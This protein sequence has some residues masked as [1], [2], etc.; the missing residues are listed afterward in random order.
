MLLAGLSCFS[1][2]ALGANA[3]Q[4]AELVVSKR[5][6]GPILTI[7]SSGAEGNKYGFEGGRV[8]KLNGIYH[9]FTS[10]MVGDPHWVKMRLAHWT[11]TDRVHWKRPSTA[12]RAGTFRERSARGV[13]VAAP[14]L[15]SQGKPLESVLRCLPGGSGHVGEVANQS[16]GPHLADCFNDCREEGIGGPYRDVGVIL[17]RGK[18][19]GFMGGP[20]RN[21][22]I[23]SLPGGRPL[24][25]ILRQ[26]AHREASDLIVAGGSGEVT[27][28]LAPGC[29]ARSLI[30]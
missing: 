25:R 13:V 3:G 16:R 23:L 2:W 20:A 26:C 6:H 15:R 11:S 29:G 9:L 28:S 8:L 12:N 10:E 18:R 17:Q 14:S 4:A 24:V 30:R 5:F 27:P 21:G 22:L 7:K 1:F 19:L